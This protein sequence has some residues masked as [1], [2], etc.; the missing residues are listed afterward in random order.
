MKLLLILLSSM[1]FIAYAYGVF[2]ACYLS[3]KKEPKPTEMPAFL[4]SVVTSIGGVLATNLG[5]VIGFA[6][7]VPGSTAAKNI[8][9][10]F[11]FFV[12]AAFTNL[13]ITASYIYL[14]FLF[15]AATVWAVKKFTGDANQIVPVL[16]E[17]TKTLLGVIVGA[18]GII[19][20][21]L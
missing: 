16:P 18:M 9:E 17:M 20:A 15:I 12:Y 13:Q 6:I 4:A 10:P 3:L 14:L 1:G 21:K 5:A 11:A 2:Y 19:L 8:G 7:K